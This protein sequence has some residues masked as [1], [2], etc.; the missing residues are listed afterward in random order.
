MEQYF[1]DKEEKM[2]EE[3]EKKSGENQT[4][5]TGFFGSLFSNPAPSAAGLAKPD[6]YIKYLSVGGMAAGA[7]IIMGLGALAVQSYMPGFM[8]FS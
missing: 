3:Q 1:K 6:K 5:N 4:Q 7:F 8:G 2:R